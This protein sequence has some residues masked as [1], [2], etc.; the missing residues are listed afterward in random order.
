[1]N[2]LLHRLKQ[3]KI[4]CLAWVILSKMTIV[5]EKELKLL[6]RFIN[7]GDIVLDIG[8]N[9]GS[10]TYAISS[11][12]GNSGKVFAF[13]PLPDNLRILSFIKK[14]LRLSNTIIIPEALSEKQGKM[15][16]YVPTIDGAK[17]NTRAY[18]SPERSADCINV[19]VTTISEIAD[20]HKINRI[21]F[22]KCDAEGAEAM[23]FRGGENIIK[24]CRPVILCELGAA[25]ANYGLNDYDVFNYIKGM[26][27]YNVYVFLNN[28][29]NPVDVFKEEYSNYIFTKQVYIEAGA[30][31]T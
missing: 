27:D 21:D 25:S 8:A 28:K 11:T 31:N 12:V 17:K 18:L 30:M 22:I 3:N 14:F 2:K 9:I 4:I 26:C 13:E 5:N 6:R 16:L 20:R 15:S 1:M 23:V 29:L 19:N 7:K 10:Y 24:K